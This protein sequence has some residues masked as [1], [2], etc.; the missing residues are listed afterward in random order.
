MIASVLVASV[1]GLIGCGG[2]EGNDTG[3]AYMPD[4]YYSRAYE[5]YGYNNKAEDHD[6][7]ARGARFNGTPVAGSIARG[8]AFSFPMPPGDSGY[9][10]AASY[11]VAPEQKMM[12]PQQMKEG[13]RLY[14]INC[15]IC[16][17]ANL[18][19]NGPLY[20]GGNGPYPVAP[21]NLKDDYTK[22]LSDG[23]IYHVITYGK[24][25]MG[26]YAGQLHPQQRWWVINYIRGKQGPADSAAAKTAAPA[27]TATAA[28]GDSTATKTN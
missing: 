22:N 10:R 25:Q 15:G 12:T 23:Q 8:D 11:Q 6:L 9:A 7:A 3:S 27:G 1:A 19:G 18:D 21:R 4:M 13:E 17:G 28:G 26:S 20:N 14:L 24:G 2:A 16:H 5:A